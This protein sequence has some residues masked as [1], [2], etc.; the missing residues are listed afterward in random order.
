MR[1]YAPNVDGKA[2]TKLEA[3]CHKVRADA[4][5]DEIAFW[6]HEKAPLAKSNMVG[7]LQTAVPPCFA[8]EAFE[9]WR[10]QRANA[11]PCPYCDGRGCKACAPHKLCRGQGCSGCDFR[12]WL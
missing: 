9:L 10:E 5:K 12:G 6:I 7:F 3:D 1:T 2:I 8:G 11:P 4:T